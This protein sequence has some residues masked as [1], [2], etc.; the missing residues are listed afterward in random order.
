MTAAAPPPSTPLPRPPVHPER[1]AYLG[2]PEMAVPPL[3]ALHAAGFDLAVVVT[4][5]DKRRGRRGEPSPSP[6]KAAALE[7]GLPVV[8]DP[9]AALE[10]GADLGV[11][12]AYG[13]I[14]RRPLL[15]RLPMVNLH[16]SLLPRWRGAAPVERAIL[17]GD[18]RTGV[19][20]MAVDETLDTGDVYAWREVPIDPSTHAD[21]V[22]RELTDVGS[23]LLV[24]ALRAGLADPEPQVGATTYAEKLTSDDRHIDWTVPAV[25]IHRQVRVGGAWTTFRGRRFKVLDAEVADAV[26]VGRRGRPGELDGDEVATGDGGLRLVQVQPEGKAPTDAR[27][28]A[29]GARPADGERFGGEG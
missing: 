24:D 15:E 1:L 17:A 2:T 27:S 25:Q 18:D 13:R 11:V 4:R 26:G 5:P 19:C 8:H 9:E 10:H 3:R 22:A 12:V 21:V 6:V 28:W 20:V 7:L 14:L 16:F 23:A 29:N